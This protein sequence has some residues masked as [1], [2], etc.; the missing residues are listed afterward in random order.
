MLGFILPMWL[1]PKGLSSCKHH[2]QYL[3]LG[4]LATSPH[5][6]SYLREVE[7][8]LMFP[9]ACKY[10]APKYSSYVVPSGSLV[11]HLVSSLNRRSLVEDRNKQKLPVQS[12]S[13]FQNKSCQVSRKY[14]WTYI[15]DPKHLYC[16]RRKGPSQPWG[17]K[18]ATGGAS[19][20]FHLPH[21][22][23]TY[24]KPVPHYSTIPLRLPT[25]LNY[26]LPPFL[27]SSVSLLSALEVVIGSEKK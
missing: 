5:C 1:F 6:S 22:P 9:T 4:F 20:S 12:L 16:R 17:Q 26:P 24:L 25:L 18:K 10:S 23:F 2:F 7:H 8:F 21:L 15:P 13:P 19:G 11:K 3:S 14:M 27:N